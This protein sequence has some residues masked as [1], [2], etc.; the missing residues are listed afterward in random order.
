MLVVLQQKEERAF[1]P[2]PGRMAPSQK[3]SE[4]KQGHSAINEVVIREYTIN[5]DKRIH[6]VGFKKR[7]PR[8]LE[9]K[10]KTQIW[11]FAVK[12]MGTPDVHIDS[13]LSKAVCAKGIRNIPYCIWVWLSRKQ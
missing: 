10:T 3:G 1:Q 11:K 12:E 6:G 5:V 4:K 9:G 8:D 13:R 2:G 7:A